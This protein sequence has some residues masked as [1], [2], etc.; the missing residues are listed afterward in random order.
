M[1]GSALPVAFVVDGRHVEVPDEGGSLLDAL[2]GRLGINSLKDGCS[3]QGQCGCCTVLVDGQPRVACVTPARRV[4]GRSITTLEGLQP[5]ERET[6]GDAFCATGA[7][8]CGF[9]TPGIVM[10]LSGL[11]A[12]GTAADDHPAVEQ[13]L[14]AHLCRCT[15]W[16]TILDAWSAYGEPAGPTAGSTV[17]PQVGPPPRDLAAAGRRAT[18]EGHTP[19]RVDPEIPLGHGGFADDTAPAGAL[20]AVPDGAGGWTVGESVAEAR[21][22]AGKVQGRRTTA[23]LRHPLEPPP[24]NWEVTLRTTWVEPAYLELDASWCI[25]GREPASPLAN[26]GAFGGKR[27]SVVTRAARELADRHGRPVRVLLAREDAVRLGAKRPP[28]AAGIHPDGSGVMR[29]ARTEGIADMVASV[30]PGLV[31]E[32]VDVAGPPTSLAPRATGWA[33][34]L[35]L[36]AAAGAQGDAGAQRTGTLEATQAGDRARVGLRSPDGAMAHAEVDLGAEPRVDVAVSC[37]DP[38]DEVALRSYC[39]GAAH[40]ALGWVC[41]EGLAVDAAGEVHDLTIRSFGVLRAVDTPPIDVTIEPSDGPPVNGSDAAFAAVA[42]AAWLA[43]G[44]PPAW[45]TGHHIRRSH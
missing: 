10:R 42:A 36:L 30:A 34:A 20:V 21:A 26:G 18:I 2:R 33:E 1:P 44:C 4:R 19:Q 41:S 8:Q 37:G 24:G 3:P 15:G 6:W 13:A 17:G 16:R 29:V 23:E 9:C 43:Q 39:V 35:V 28:I 38:L 25:P 40:M 27:A 32:Q 12:R 22:A 45:P 11:R 14:L 5:A 7:S 31:V